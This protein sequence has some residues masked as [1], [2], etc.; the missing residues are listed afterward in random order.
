MLTFGQDKY[1]FRVVGWQ[2]NGTQRYCY[3]AAV[4]ELP[5]CAAMVLARQYVGRKSVAVYM[6][7]AVRDLT[8]QKVKYSTARYVQE[9]GEWNLG[10]DCRL[11]T[12]LAST[13]THGNLLSSVKK[14]R[15]L[16]R[17]V[18]TVFLARKRLDLHCR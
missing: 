11:E 13:R 9:L 5:T 3:S 7:R 10:R 18:P 12:S 15:T 2:R 17:I 14:Q 8:S 4:D 16:S 6:R 1:Q